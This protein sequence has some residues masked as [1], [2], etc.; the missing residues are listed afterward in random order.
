MAKFV[1]GKDGSG[2]FVKIM[3]NDADDPLTVP[4]SDL[5]KFHFNSRTNK[6]GYVYDVLPKHVTSDFP[7]GGSGTLNNY[8]VPS[9]TNLNTCDIA[10]RSN[11]GSGGSSTRRQYVYWFPERMFGDAGPGNYVPW[12]ELRAKY[13]STTRWPGPNVRW[14]QEAESGMVAGSWTG[15]PSIS[16]TQV[17]PK[18]DN[19]SIFDYFSRMDEMMTSAVFEV[20]AGGHAEGIMTIWDMPMNEAALINPTGTPVAGQQTVIISPSMVKIARP[21]YDVGTATE[22]QLVLSSERVPAKIVRAG[23]I[24]VAGSSYADI[25]SPIPL[26]EYSVLDY[27]AKRNSDSKLFHPPHLD[28]SSYGDTDKIDFDYEFFSNYVRIYNNDSQALYVRYLLLTDDGSEPTAGGVKVL[29][30][31]N[32][33]TQDFIQIK[34]PGSSDSAPHTSD[35]LLDS[36]FAYLPMVAEGYI[37]Y[38]AFTDTPTSTRQG[39]A[40]KIITFENNG[41]KPFLKFS[42]VYDTDVAGFTKAKHPYSKLLY[43][44][45]PTVYNMRQAREGAPAKIED[46]Q[47]TFHMSPTNPSFI[48]IISGSYAATNNEPPI[49][50]RYYIFAIPND[51]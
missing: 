14:G 19:S 41:F 48:Q 11:T 22:R 20:G 33:G 27:H 10:V 9:G 47:I 6:V 35:I 43:Q 28:G 26:S 18:N 17:S 31:G 30:K 1:Y 24:V 29:H 25:V 44:S 49:G 50:I 40:A 46:T 34:K 36:R 16:P 21:G 39:N 8:Y 5:S 38:S 12:W 37:P 7:F 2:P 42:L 23:E 45:P 32:D 15:T 4:D 51:L 3:R 13:N